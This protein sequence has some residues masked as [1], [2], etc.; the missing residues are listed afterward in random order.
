MWHNVLTQ[1]FPVFFLFADPGKKCNTFNQ[2]TY[3]SAKT[4][5]M[6][7]ISGNHSFLFLCKQNCSICENILS[8]TSSLQLNFMF[9]LTNT[10]KGFNLSITDTSSQ[11]ES[12][13]WCGVKSNDENY[14]E[15]LG[16]IQLHVLGEE[17]TSTTRNITQLGLG[18]S[19]WYYHV[20]T[21]FN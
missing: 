6:C 8:S 2:T 19:T 10:T 16:K 11:D 13:Y 9:T 7:G 17:W 18:M 3:K 15:T 14:T 1:C 5:N 20:N 4:T 21:L 12:V